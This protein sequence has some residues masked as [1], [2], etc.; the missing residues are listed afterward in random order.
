MTNERSLFSIEKNLFFFILF[1]LTDLPV[2]AEKVDEKTDQYHHHHGHHHVYLS[3]GGH[4]ILLL[5][6]I[7]RNLRIGMSNKKNKKT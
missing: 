2:K 5:L 4:E 1:K 6:V 7:A 3:I